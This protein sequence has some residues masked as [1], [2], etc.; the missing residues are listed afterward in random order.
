MALLKPTIP[1]LSLTL[2]GKPKPDAET[3]RLIKTLGLETAIEY[4]HGIS[5][6][7]MVSCYSRA[8]VAVVPSLY[9]GFG[10]PAIEAMACGVPLVSSDGGALP[11][12]VGDTARIVPAGDERE[13]AEA[14]A[15][16]LSST[17]ERERLAQAGRRRALEEFCWDRCAERMVTY[18]REIIAAC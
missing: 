13:L 16:L 15:A 4:R 2:I 12:V 14:I 10:L 17:A 1:E 5:A 8:A 11:E 6:E 9:E 7:E 3:E 18:Y